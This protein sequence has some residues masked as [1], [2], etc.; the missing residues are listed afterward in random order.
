[1]SQ[2]KSTGTLLQRHS[3]KE[4][5]APQANRFGHEQ[6][7]FFLFPKFEQSSTCTVVLPDKS[8]HIKKLIMSSGIAV[9]MY[10]GGWE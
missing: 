6:P 8:F 10:L 2:G 3:L 7:I 4:S 5:T 9:A 1:M